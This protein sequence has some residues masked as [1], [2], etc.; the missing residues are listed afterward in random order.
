MKLSKY[1]IIDTHNIDKTILLAGSGRSGTTWVEN[2][3]NYDNSKRIIFEPFDTTKNRLISHWPPKL[4][5]D[6]DENRPEYVEPLT[7]ILSG[8]LRS[9]W[10]DQFNKKVWS[11]SRLIKAIRANSLLP[12]IHSLYPDLPIVFLMRHPCAVTHSRIKM[13]WGTDNSQFLKQEKLAQGILKPFTDILL[14]NHDNFE[15]H[16]LHWCVENYIPLKLMSKSSMHVIFYEDL[17]QQKHQVICDLFEAV[18]QE[19]PPHDKL[20]L[21]KP[22][23]LSREESAILKGGDLL[24]SWKAHISQSQIDSAVAML[25]QFGLQKIYSNTSLP[26]IPATEVLTLL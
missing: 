19:C 16:I 24:E 14:G 17:V 2:L 15:N 7:R 26:L 12:W 10:T 8:Q 11:S 22:S 5:L 21:S 6:V 4:F 13:G 18:G 25:T 20:G 23:A 9:M 1:V 3:I